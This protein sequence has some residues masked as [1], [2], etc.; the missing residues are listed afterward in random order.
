MLKKFMSIT[1]A[2]FVSMGFLFAQEDASG[3]DNLSKRELRKMEKQ[4]ERETNLALYKEVAEEKAWVIEAHT[5]F[6]KY[7]RSFQMDPTI[8]F[9]SVTG[10]ET[11]IQLGVHGFIGY[12]GL[13]GITLDGMITNYEVNRDGD[14]ILIGYTAMGAL[15]GPI[16]MIARISSEGYGRITLSG[17]W[18]R[19][20]TFAGYFVPYDTSRTYTG[21]PVY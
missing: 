20:M 13:G 6:N 8:N 3:S 2:L 4:K 21:T 16:D 11:I 17:N 1:L 5:I 19:R 12:N 9:V 14:S 7:G 18:G 10:E 15:M